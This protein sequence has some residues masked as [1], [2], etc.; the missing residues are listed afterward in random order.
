MAVLLFVADSSLQQRCLGTSWE[1][2][3]QQGYTW[4]I[5]LCRLDSIRL[6][7]NALAVWPPWQ[8][9]VNNR[10]ECSHNVPA[11]YL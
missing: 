5:C 1:A 6:L 9:S 2:A 8:V 4:P 3:C 11:Y 7:A 10:M